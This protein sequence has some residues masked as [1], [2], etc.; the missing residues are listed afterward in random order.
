MI[1]NAYACCFIEWQNASLLYSAATATPQ[2]SQD[3]I[4]GILF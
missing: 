4:W 2:T 3:G 1:A